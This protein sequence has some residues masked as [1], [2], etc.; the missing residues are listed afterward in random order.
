[1]GH[2][3]DHPKRK[4]DREGV[5][6][7]ASAHVLT[8]IGPCFPL[9]RTVFLRPVLGFRLMAQVCLALFFFSSFEGWRR[10]NPALEEGQKPAVERFCLWVGGGVSV[11]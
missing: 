4:I 11:A 5:G 7:F 9:R 2:Q 1:M 8:G 3:G 6:R 10:R